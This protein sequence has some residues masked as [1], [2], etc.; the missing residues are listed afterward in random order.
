MNANLLRTRKQKQ[1]G[2]ATVEF[3]LILPLFLAILF[4][5]AFSAMIFYS[6]VTL[7]M[8]S[9]EG[10][11]AVVGNPKATTYS[12]RLT[13]CNTAFALV[14]NSVSVKIEPP[15][16]FSTTASS[17]SSLNTGEGVYSGYVTD[18]RVAVTTFYTI[19]IP[20]ITIPGVGQSTVFFGPVTI[21]S[22]SVMTIN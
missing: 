11:R 19:P 1:Q 7:T 14:R 6:Y 18:M 5:L 17:C 21:Q 9:R 22:I 2:Q 15:D 3:A 4:G 12:A 10:A 16:T 13:A 20:S 8:A